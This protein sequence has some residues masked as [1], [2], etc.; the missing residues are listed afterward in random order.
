MRAPRTA[1]FTLI[2][3]LIV[4]A[5]LGLLAAVLMPEILGTRETAN[6]AASKAAM[7]QLETGCRTYSNKHG[8]YPTDDLKN[9]E[10]NAVQ[11]KADNGQNTGIES[12]VVFLSQSRQDGEDLTG[13]AERHSNTDKDEHGA[14][15]PLLHTKERK[16]IADAWGMPL[17]YFSKFGMEKTQ[18]VTPPDGDPMPVKAR[19][20]E[21]GTFFGAGKFQLLSAGKDSVFGTEDD[22]VWPEN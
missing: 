15:L 16:E 9:P 5:I 3:L 12:L 6:A 7:L 18:Q 21:D 2:E 17:C 13:L 19:R 4:I 20:R 1:G 11:W 10:S 14:E 8:Y 22:L